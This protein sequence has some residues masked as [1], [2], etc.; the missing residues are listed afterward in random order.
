MLCA[1][2]ATYMHALH[3]KKENL[4]LSGSCY[5]VGAGYYPLLLKPS[6]SIKHVQLF[7]GEHVIVG[8]HTTA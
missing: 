2:V 6:T 8:W 5:A 7:M 4:V 1:S 3:D